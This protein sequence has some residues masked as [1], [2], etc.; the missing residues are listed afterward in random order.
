MSRRGSCFFPSSP[1]SGRKLTA[2][3][4]VA[5]EPADTVKT[6]V[7]RAANSYRGPAV[8]CYLSQAQT[9]HPTLAILLRHGE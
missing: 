1:A 8:P 6:P 7:R 2:A 4:M 3:P 9:R 5:G